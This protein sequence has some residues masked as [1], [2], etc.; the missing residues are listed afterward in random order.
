MQLTVIGQSRSD[1]FIRPTGLLLIRQSIRPWPNL[2]DRQSI[3]PAVTSRVK[4]Q[5][6]ELPASEQERACHRREH[7]R[8]TCT[9]SSFSILHSIQPFVPTFPSF[10]SL[11]RNGYFY[12]A[13]PCS[14]SYSIEPCSFSPTEQNNQHGV[15]AHLGFK[16]YGTAYIYICGRRQNKTINRLS[17]LS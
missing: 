17:R 6:F 3:R 13:V 9:R 4:I 15:I 11:Q 14:I 2:L 5:K 1:R 8:V 16:R 12:Y 10:P 7:K